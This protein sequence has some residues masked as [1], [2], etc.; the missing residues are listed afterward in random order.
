MSMLNEQDDSLLIGLLLA[1]WS[2]DLVQITQQASERLLVGVVVL[3]LAEV[4]DM[5]RAANAGCPCLGGL[6]HG[7]VE[8]DGEQDEFLTLVL[9]VYCG[10]HLFFHP[11]ALDRVL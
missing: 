7:I 10:C 2:G 1:L 4:P 11:G 8:L 3:P 9:L 5:A 6:H